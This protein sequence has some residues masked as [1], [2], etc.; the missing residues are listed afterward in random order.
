MKNL[1][2]LL[3]LLFPILGHAQWTD[4]GLDQQ[5]N[6]MA[7]GDMISVG[8]TLL[9]W[10]GS[11]GI[12]RST[13]NGATWQDVDPSD[14]GGQNGFVAKFAASNGKIWAARSYGSGQGMLTVS[15]DDG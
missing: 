3:V 6:N 10:N 2:L 15:T 8:N 12:V 9:F 5:G 11:L 13:D 7:N 14:N 1:L 4:G